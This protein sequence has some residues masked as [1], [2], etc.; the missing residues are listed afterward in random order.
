MALDKEN[1]FF[2]QGFLGIGGKDEKHLRSFLP[3]F[4]LVI[5]QLSEYKAI[6]N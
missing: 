2:S 5:N 4:Y 1:V 3:T 6:P